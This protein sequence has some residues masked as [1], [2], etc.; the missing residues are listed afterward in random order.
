MNSRQFLPVIGVLIA[1]VVIS[2]AF[3]IDETNQVVITQMGKP[4]RTVQEPGLY[5]KIPYPIQEVNRFD[6]RLLVY[7]S[8]PTEIITKD[9]KNLVIDNYALWKI[10][11]PLKFMQAVRDENGAQSRLD[12]IIYS[13]VRVE[14]GKYDL[15]DIVATSRHMIM[16]TVTAKVAEKA[17]DYGIEV[18]DVRIKR[19]D[20]PQENEKA[21]F[22]RMRAERKRM[23]NQYRSE[24]D[25]EALKIRAETDKEKTIIMAE[26]YKEAQK[27]KGDGDA[28]AAS[29]YAGAFGRDPLFYEFTR[30]LESYEIAIDSKTTIVLSPDAE[31]F[32]YLWK[33]GY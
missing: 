30:T 31:F 22:E 8:A 17:I 14:L 20:L 32:K 18:V 15:H 3:V 2:S 9:K 25:E 12:D 24:G 21:V 19:A 27:T 11:E 4:V 16:Q 5:F 13:M 10:V 26:A 29:I 6:D 23:A 7:D 28:E 1:I 33:S